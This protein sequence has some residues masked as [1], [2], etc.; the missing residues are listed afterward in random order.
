[1]GSPEPYGALL[2]RWKWVVQQLGDVADIVQP[3]QQPS[4]WSLAAATCP[5]IGQLCV[6]SMELWGRHMGRHCVVDKIVTFWGREFPFFSAFDTTD[7][8]P[9]QTMPRMS[10]SW[11]SE[12]GECVCW[13]HDCSSLQHCSAAA[14]TCTAHYHLVFHKPTWVWTQLSHRNY[15]TFYRT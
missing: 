9:I 6:V 11:K 13:Y 5:P 10:L 12:P 14:L 2:S 3:C 15:R 8:G 4:Y 7:S 1:M